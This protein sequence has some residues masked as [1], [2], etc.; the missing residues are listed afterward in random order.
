MKHCKI[1]IIGL[2]FILGSSFVPEH[3]GWANYDRNKVHDYTGEIVEFTFEN[4]HATARVKD[5][6]KT[7]FVVLAPTSRMESRG[8]P[9]DKLKK[10][11]SLRVV[12]YE[13]KEKKDE[14]RAERI[15][16]DGEKFELR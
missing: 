7:W 12:G 9:V 15:F 2:L 10:G 16:V 6:N 14:M 1:I 8:V 11:S 4:P 13:H 5:K 3:H